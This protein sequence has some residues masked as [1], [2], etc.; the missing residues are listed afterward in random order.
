MIQRTMRERFA[1]RRRLAC[2]LALGLC[3]ALFTALGTEMRSGG[4]HSPWWRLVGL[5]AL[6]TAGFGALGWL[7]LGGWKR[8]GKTAPE[9]EWGFSRFAG[10]GFAVFLLLAVCW[11]P[12]WLAYWP[13]LLNPD[14]LSQF[15]SFYNEDPSAH[16]PLLHTALLGF[17]M[18]VGIGLHP[19]GYAT[20]GV[21][22]YCGVQL[23]L[24]A[25]CAAYGCAWLRRR[26][27]PLWARLAVTLV[28]A[29]SPVYAPWAASTHKD[30]LFGA[31]ALVFCLQLA[32]LWRFGFK[33]LRCAA[34]A[35]SALCM[36]A[37]RNNGVYALALLLPFAAGWARAGRRAATAALLLGCALVYGAGNRGVIAALDARPGEKVEILSI[38]LQ[39]IARTLRD[40]P[41]A[42]ELDG[43][44]LLATL[45]GEAQPAELYH[46]Q[47]A[48]PVKWAADNDALEENLS[49]LLALWGRMGLRYP[50]SYAEA[51]LVQNLPYYLPCSP[52]L[53]NFDLN[54][55]E[56]EWFPVEQHS[57]LPGLRKAYEAY[58][59]TLC[60][61][62]LPGTRLF[63]HPATMVWLCVFGFVCAVYL[64]RRGLMAA[65][66][67]LLA[68]WF[69]CLLGPVA[70]LRYVLGLFDAV[71]VLLCALLAPEPQTG[72]GRF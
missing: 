10:N 63:S 22:L 46:P 50:Q 6:Y 35:A 24:L 61:A 72:K 55:Q 18:T 41:E 48:D 45:Y 62:G 70:I 23:V 11:L 12:A 31:A 17:C 39:Q 13:G 47:I 4:F 34:F 27:A 36:M 64:H 21:A 30:V 69:T 32:D 71:P 59:R 65:F 5:F 53:Y 67:F 29:L 25:A 52:M 66:L 51:F 2:A 49:G 7:A 58:D 43:D 68:I 56:P 19:E 9:R 16:H 20:Y 38:P 14:T 15:E 60:F 3:Y 40:H 8:L 28:F 54:A 1:D 33:P 42:A 44:G 57:Y 26:G 37:L